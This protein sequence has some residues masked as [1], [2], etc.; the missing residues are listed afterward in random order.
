[1][2]KIQ[3]LI[4]CLA[5]LNQIAA[6]DSGQILAVNSLENISLPLASK[7]NTLGTPPLD[8]IDEN[9]HVEAGGWPSDGVQAEDAAHETENENTLDTD[10]QQQLEPQSENLVESPTAEDQ[11]SESQNQVENQDGVQPEQSYISNLNGSEDGKSLFEDTQ[12]DGQATPEISSFK[13]AE[14]EPFS[15]SE[16]SFSAGDGLLPDQPPP[17]NVKILNPD[18]KKKQDD[19]LNQ[20]NQ[21]AVKPAGPVEKLA[22]AKLTVGVKKFAEDYEKKL[23]KKPVV[24]TELPLLISSITKNIKCDKSGHLTILYQSDPKVP[25]SELKRSFEKYMK[26]VGATKEIGENLKADKQTEQ[27]VNSKWAITILQFFAGVLQ[28]PLKD[29]KSVVK[30]IVSTNFMELTMKV[31]E[32]NLGL[33]EHNKENVP[34]ECKAEA[35]LKKMR[36]NKKEICNLANLMVLALSHIFAAKNNIIVP[37]FYKKRM[38]FLPL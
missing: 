27:L 34:Q 26:K 22:P 21:T 24:P 13:P 6:R 19:L 3:A 33:K 1:M 29:E 16:T 2:L 18:I 9:K 31:L 38:G 28:S 23:I 37:F 4:F 14:G 32:N 11:F 36:G 15:N 10:G 12:P 5:T 8:N 20:H 7:A 25:E 17:R 35:E 30:K